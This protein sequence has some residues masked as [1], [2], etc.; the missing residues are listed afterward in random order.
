[1]RAHAAEM[2][3]ET[4]RQRVWAALVVGAFFALPFLGSA[5]GGGTQQL[6]EGLHA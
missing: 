3:E 6:S 1:M 2:E 4:A 5:N